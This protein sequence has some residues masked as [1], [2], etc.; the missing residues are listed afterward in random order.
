MDC[1]PI[2]IRERER[3]DA[4]AGQLLKGT[5]VEGE[6]KWSLLVVRVPFFFVRAQGRSTR[7]KHTPLSDACTIATSVN[8]CTLPAHFPIHRES[9]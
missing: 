8:R 2:R 1:L 6:G 7:P 5:I 9:F 4:K 3:E